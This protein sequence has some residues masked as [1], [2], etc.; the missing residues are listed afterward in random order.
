MYKGYLAQI[1]CYPETHNQSVN[2][3]ISALYRTDQA[4]AC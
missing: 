4:N 3:H 2:V 1:C